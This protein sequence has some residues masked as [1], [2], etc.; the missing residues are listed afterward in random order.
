MISADKVIVNDKKDTMGHNGD[1]S[2]CVLRSQTGT[3]PASYFIANK[4]RVALKRLQIS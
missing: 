1:G 4:N 2:F 3:A